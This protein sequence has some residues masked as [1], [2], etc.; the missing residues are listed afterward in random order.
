MVAKKALQLFTTS[1]NSPI[2]AA[3]TQGNRDNNQ[4]DTLNRKTSGLGGNSAAFAS[5]GLARNSNRRRAPSESYPFP[6]AD[7]PA[8]EDASEGISTIGSGPGITRRKTDRQADI[9][10]QNDEVATPASAA[11]DSTTGFGSIKR[12]PFGP[13]S[14]ALNGPASPWGAPAQAASSPMGAF[15][16]IGFGSTPV[17]S[18]A[19]RPGFGS[20][21]GGSRFA[22]LMKTSVEDE[23]SSLHSKPSLGSFGLSDDPASRRHTPALVDDH[24]ERAV[25]RAGTFGSAALGGLH[26]ISDSRPESANPAKGRG[27]H[28]GHLHGNGHDQ[29]FSSGDPNSP[30]YTNPYQSPPHQSN[31]IKDLADDMDMNV[32]P[33]LGGFQRAPGQD[34]S[35]GAFSESNE[36]RH[37]Q[38]PYDSRHF[39]R[40]EAANRGF[41][42]LGALGGLGGLPGLGSPGPWSSGLA[43]TTP[44]RERSQGDAFGDHSMRTPGAFGSPSVGTGGAFGGSDR[45][46]GFGG[47]G[48]IGRGSKLSSLYS[49]STQDQL[50]GSR[51]DGNYDQEGDVLGGLGGVGR[52]ETE[53]PFRAGR[54]KFDDFFHD[55]QGDQNQTYSPAS[56]LQTPLHQP[57]PSQRVPS[58]GSSSSNQIPAA[59]QKTMVMPDRIRWVYK[60][61]QGNTQGPWT[62]LEMHDWYRAGFFSPELLVKKVEDADYEPLAQLIRR[63]GNSR[64]PFLVPQIGIPGPAASQA[65]APSN[66]PAQ[67]APQA[68]TTQP[69]FAGSF[70]SFGT[71]LTADQQNAL[72]RRK[73]EEQYLMHQQKEHLAW[74]QNVAK[75]MQLQGQPGF[76]RQGLS[77]QQSMQS[78]HSQPSYGS[79]NSP[80]AYQAHLATGNGAAY[81]A[82]T[83]GTG[84]GLIG[85]GT[86]NLGNI[87][88]ESMPGAFERHDD[89]SSYAAQAPIGQQRGHED[90]GNEQRVAAMLADRARLAQEQAEQDTLQET[91]PATNERLNE[92]LSTL[93]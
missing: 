4:R 86:D 14:A 13:I 27:G 69:P 65:A 32:L 21:R 72:E 42:G 92:F 55:K 82:F 45:F 50:L 49:G 79:T 91:N 8:G 80:S 84:A 64:E 34:P 59:Q 66:W 35:I 88:E 83:R 16:G 44:G 81:D 62:G 67:N 71:T 36:N 37:S 78:L 10:E 12:N 3:T 54:G 23:P 20:T 89:G 56:A 39:E 46:G 74:Q 76:G 1:V 30:T 85:S 90:S 47:T 43:T 48:T 70:P 5:P 73:Q 9:V 26:D 7:A 63:I 87:R 15:R 28:H 60:D 38:H 25:S 93:R 61:P 52:R 75:Q 2:K 40:P 29:D 6:S 58:V 11:P 53:S 31:S 51:D 18:S 41:P 24:S 19:N 33:G 57:G 22:D 77:H 17:T 68:P